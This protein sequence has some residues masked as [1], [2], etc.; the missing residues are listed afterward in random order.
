MNWGEVIRARGNS[1]LQLGP[2]GLNSQKVLNSKTANFRTDV[3]RCFYLHCYKAMTL[4][5][6]LGVQ[7]KNRLGFLEALIWLQVYLIILCYLQIAR[8]NGALGTTSA[9][10]EANLWQVDLL[11]PFLV[12]GQR[13]TIGFLPVYRSSSIKLCFKSS[14]TMTLKSRKSCSQNT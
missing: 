12:Q 13:A 9:I 10:Y 5:V 2:K 7:S 6:Y 11:R 14:F 8:H 4:T 1:E 3:G